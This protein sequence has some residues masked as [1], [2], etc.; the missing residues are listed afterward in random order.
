MRLLVVLGLGGLLGVALAGCAS[1]GSP[2]AAE[3][4]ARW[5]AENIYPETYKRDLLAFLR[6]YLNDPEHVRAAQASQPLR[7][8]MGPGERFVV[9]VRFSERKTAGKYASKDGIATYVSG[10]LDR[11][12]DVPPEEVKSLCMDVPLAPFPERETLTR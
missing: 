5:E 3:L 2:S 11:F 7:K 8:T 6:T 9:C 10:K 1:D 4:K 12:F